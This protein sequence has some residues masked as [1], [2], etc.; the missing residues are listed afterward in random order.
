MEGYLPPQKLK[1]V[2]KWLADNQQRAETIFYE[3]NPGL[4]LIN[5]KKKNKTPV[6]NKRNKKRKK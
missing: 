3:L 2:Q 4:S 5:Y 6:H 1:I